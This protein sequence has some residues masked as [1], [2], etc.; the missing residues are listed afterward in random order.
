M[1]RFR[2]SLIA[3][4]LAASFAATLAPAFAAGP[5]PAAFVDSI[6]AHGHE[7]N[8]WSQ[9][10]DGHKRVAWVSRGLATLW[11]R[12]DASARKAKDEM[13]ALDSDVAT[14]SQLG[15][16]SFKAYAVKVVSQDGAHAVVEAR[17]TVAANT[18]APKFDSD[19]VI[20]Y[21]LVQ[22]GGAWK[23]DDVHSTVDGKPWGLRE[24]L[25]AYLKI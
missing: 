7:D 16:E 11:G 14:N 19:N 4:I 1:P 9:W 23:I 24:I 18:E 20:R 6:Y 10:L 22:E 13:G 12:C 8:V 2:L 25:K 17:L 15:W 5:D 3:A 21:D